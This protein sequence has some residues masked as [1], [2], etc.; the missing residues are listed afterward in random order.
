L[1]EEKNRFQPLCLPGRILNLRIDTVLSSDGQE[2]T[3]EIIEHRGC[4]AVVPVDDQ[5]NILLVRQY[6]KALE[7]YLVEIPA[8]G[9]RPAKPRK[10]PS[11]VSCRRKSALPRE[12]R[13]AGRLLFRP[14]ILQRVSLPVPGDST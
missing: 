6:R 7:K 2:K 5:G 12:G 11:D 1:A 9:S 8:A 14:G 13:A 10:L 4:I 3:R